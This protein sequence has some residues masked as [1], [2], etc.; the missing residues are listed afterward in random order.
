MSTFTQVYNNL[1]TH[2]GT[3]DG[4]IVSRGFG[5]SETAGVDHLLLISL[6]LSPATPQYMPWLRRDCLQMAVQ[7]TTSLEQHTKA[8]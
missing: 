4:N 1:N 7:P 3:L 5:M 8:T 2:W 6:Q